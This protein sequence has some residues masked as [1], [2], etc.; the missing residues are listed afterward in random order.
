MK[1]AFC[2]C[3]YNKCMYID[4]RVCGSHVIYYFVNIKLYL[5]TK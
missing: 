1:K 5:P 2:L 3:V 4:I